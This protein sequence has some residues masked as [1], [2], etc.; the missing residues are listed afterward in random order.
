LT[1]ITGGWSAEVN[2][3]GT[4]LGESTVS[5]CFGD[6]LVTLGITSTSSLYGVG[7]AIDQKT[8]SQ[9]LVLPLGG[10]ELSVAYEGVVSSS[11]TL[12]SSGSGSVT[13]TI[14][15]TAS[16]VST[17]E[18][19]HDILGFADI[20][21]EGCLSGSGTGIASADGIAEY[22]VKTTGSASEVWGSV[23]G[24]STLNMVGLSSNS[25]TSSGGQPNGL[26]IE[27]RSTKNHKRG[28]EFIQHQPD[29]CCCLSHQ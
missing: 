19:S 24:E 29:L 14:G 26:H 22:G 8:G 15:A 7:N 1:E 12:T 9:S 17:G 10:Y 28:G 4:S 2:G 27:S 21:T 6:P 25:L 23:S 20:T 13:S 16:G 18:G 11:L 5:S 3:E